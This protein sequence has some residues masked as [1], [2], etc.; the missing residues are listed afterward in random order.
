VFPGK[1]LNV[2]VEQTVHVSALA[3]VKPALQV[4]AVRAAL[5]SGEFELA[6]HAIHEVAPVPEPYLPTAQ[7]VHTVPITM[8][9][10][11]PAGHTV[12]ALLPTCEY[13]PTPQDTHAAGP[14]TFLY[15]PAVHVSQVNIFVYVEPTLQVHAASAVLSTG[16]FEFV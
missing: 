7:F 15:L 9:W 1:F 11:L 13:L 3:P 12:Q 10:N 2:P 16:E 4:Q 8:S 14:V 5:Y 6:G